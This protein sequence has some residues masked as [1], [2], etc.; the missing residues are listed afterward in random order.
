MLLH[1]HLQFAHTFITHIESHTHLKLDRDAFLFGNIKPDLI[2]DLY[3]PDLEEDHI[4]VKHYM[5]DAFPYVCQ[6]IESLT[7]DYRL[8]KNMTAPFSEKLGIVLHYIADFFCFAH[9]PTFNNNI[10]SH[11]LYEARLGLALNKSSQTLQL[12]TAHVQFMPVEDYYDIC[13]N[14]YLLHSQYLSS[15]PSIQTDRYYI[16]QVS[17]LTAVSIIDL[18]KSRTNI[19]AA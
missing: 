7:K 4:K 3:V 11:L 6:L 19:S 5:V 13:M 15:S 18:C 16:N 2:R 12:K 1:S 17:L 14:L 9:A 8:H 10:I